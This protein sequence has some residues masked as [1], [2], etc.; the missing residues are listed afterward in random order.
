MRRETLPSVTSSAR[1]PGALTP[2]ARSP[3]PRLSESGA[4]GTPP[5]LVHPG[6]EFH[7][8]AAAVRR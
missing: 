5:A 3:N 8:S 1:T 4:R 6:E 2:L 7:V